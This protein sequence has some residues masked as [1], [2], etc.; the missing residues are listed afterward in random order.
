MK[1]LLHGTWTEFRYR[2]FTLASF[3]A[4]RLPRRFVYWIGARIGAIVYLVILKRHAANAVSNMR[5]VLG[6]GASWQRVK[7]TAQQSFRNYG[8]LAIDFLRL[9]H[10]TDQDVY[11]VAGIPR[12]LENIDG[13]LAKGKGI[14]IITGHFGNWDLAGAS[15]A[16]LGYKLNAV[17]DTFEPEKMDRL[18]NGTRRNGGMN[19]IPVESA[20]SLKELFL[21]LKRNEIV[22][23]LFDEPQEPEKGVPVDLFGERVYLPG[24]PA[25]LALKT[26]AAI[27]IGYGYRNPDRATFTPV[28]EPEVEYKHL[29]TGDK[30]SDI[31]AIT[32]EIVRRMEIAIRERPD[33]WYMFREMWPRTP[34]HDEEVKKRRFWGGKHDMSVASG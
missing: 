2:M 8:R 25:A 4:Y 13:A 20:A 29:L 14:V 22:F 15:L 5:R 3:L 30:E 26:G 7:W 12:G 21:A 19:I 11:D 33:Q 17:A 10:M 34:E 9:P 16:R 18:I 23:L 1:R 32:Q 31:K 24:G 6:K 28:A 27:Q